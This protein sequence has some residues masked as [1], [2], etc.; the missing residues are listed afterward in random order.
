MTMLEE[1]EILT[2]KLIRGDIT[3]IVFDLINPSRKETLKD[4]II[5]LCNTS[6]DGIRNNVSVIPF[7]SFIGQK[8]RVR[9]VSNSRTV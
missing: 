7:D 2:G 9:T 4:D 3:P 8:K 5:E 6:A 1:L